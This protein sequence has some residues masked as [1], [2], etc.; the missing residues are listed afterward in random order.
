MVKLSIRRAAA[1]AAVPTPRLEIQPE[2]ALL[3]LSAVWIGVLC[4]MMLV[5][6]DVSVE[7]TATQAAVPA[8]NLS[9]AC[10]YVIYDMFTT[11]APSFP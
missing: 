4:C 5:L 9:V 8:D 1:Q 10:T 6:V 2:P 7:R 3:F 11:S